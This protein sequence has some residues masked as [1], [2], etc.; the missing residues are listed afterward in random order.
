MKTTIHISSDDTWQLAAMAEVMNDNSRWYIDTVTEKAGFH[1][2]RINH[3]YAW[4]IF[5]IG[6][7]VA[8]T[9]NLRMNE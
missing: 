2:F 5:D 6:I 3:D 9:K 1:Y 8:L 7:L 4:E